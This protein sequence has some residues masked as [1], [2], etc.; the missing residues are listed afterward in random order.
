MGSES[1]CQVK[2][3][4]C[5]CKKGKG[6]QNIVQKISNNFSI[7][8]LLFWN[9]QGFRFPEIIVTFKIGSRTGNLQ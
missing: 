8:Q 5:C 3:S 9:Y 7:D 1:F 2:L 4:Y 6:L